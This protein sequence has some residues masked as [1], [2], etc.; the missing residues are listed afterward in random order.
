MKKFIL[1]LI[2]NILIT[3]PVIAAPPGFQFGFMGSFI[4]DPVEQQTD[5]PF[6]VDQTEWVLN[7]TFNCAWDVDDHWDTT[8]TGTLKPGESASWS[9]CLFAHHDPSFRSVFGVENWYTSGQ[10][11]HAVN[12]EAGDSGLVVQECFTP[13]NR[14][15]NILPVQIE[16]KWR[17]AFCGFIRYNPGDPALEEIPNSQ[18][19]VGLQTTVTTTI[20]NPTNRRISKIAGLV[21]I[22]GQDIW[23]AGCSVPLGELQVEYP[24]NWAY[25]R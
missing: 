9:D 21:S 10:V 8:A 4:S 18:G 25:G 12:I 14:C 24:F 6:P 3:S 17:W 2:I 20:S 1:A 15:F 22:S 23:R 13:Q 19:G 11:R 5:Y 16:N 7:P